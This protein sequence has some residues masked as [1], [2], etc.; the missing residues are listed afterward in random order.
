MNL[1]LR[2]R[3]QNQEIKNIHA[4]ETYTN[5]H[6]EKLLKPK[7]MALQTKLSRWVHNIVK[8]GSFG[9]VW[10]TYHGML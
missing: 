8:N 1:A 9:H 5:V 4:L 6:D 3:F 7:P 2:H 10:Q